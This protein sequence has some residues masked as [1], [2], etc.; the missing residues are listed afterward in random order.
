MFTI[1]INDDTI[2]PIYKSV[3][4]G[5]YVETETLD[6]NGIKVKVNGIVTDILGEL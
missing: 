1:L 6:E 3:E 4:I 2:A 5:D